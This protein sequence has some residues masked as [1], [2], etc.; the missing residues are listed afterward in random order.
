MSE[1]KPAV[2][3]M[4]PIHAP[5]PKARVQS[6][7]SAFNDGVEAP[8][9]AQKMKSISVYLTE[10]EWRRLRKWTFDRDL[11]MSGVIREKLEELFRDEAI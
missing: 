8:Q 10:D 4:K 7:R 11:T 6:A 9:K 3:S 5:R 2:P 1:K